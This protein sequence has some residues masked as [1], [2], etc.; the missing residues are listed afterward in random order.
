MELFQKI[1]DQHT[2]EQLFIDSILSTFCLK[3][4]VFLLEDSTLFPGLKIDSL[5]MDT[6][7]FDSLNTHSFNLNK[8]VNDS[9]LLDT[10]RIKEITKLDS[11]IDKKRIPESE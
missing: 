8:I 10:L 4:T 11:I 7:T 5:R 9:L 3:D 1:I 6:V 2:E